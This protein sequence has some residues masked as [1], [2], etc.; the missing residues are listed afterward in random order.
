M[1]SPLMFAINMMIEIFPVLFMHYIP[2]R[3]RERFSNRINLL[4]YI[5]GGLS[6]PVGLYLICSSIPAPECSKYE[7]LFIVIYSLAAV[8]VCRFLFKVNIIK[9]LYSMILAIS[10]AVTLDFSSQFIVAVFNPDVF[11]SPGYSPVYTIGYSVVLVCLMAVT[12]PFVY[13]FI[14]NTLSEA[15]NELPIRSIA[16]FCLTPALIYILFYVYYI[17]IADLSAPPANVAFTRMAIM[18]VGLIS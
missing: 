12:L 15:I 13:R 17:T 11:A 1:K 5:I 9:Q 4:V 18:L 10:C 6:L 8:L 2:F 16:T 3:G 7:A 14:K